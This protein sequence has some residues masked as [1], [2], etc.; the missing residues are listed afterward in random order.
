MGREEMKNC[1]FIPSAFLS[2]FP[3]CSWKRIM[4]IN[5]IQHLHL[6]SHL[7]LVTLLLISLGKQVARELPHFPTTRCTHLHLNPYSSSKD[8]PF[9]LC[10]GPHTLSLSY[11]LWPS[12]IYLTIVHLIPDMLSLLFHRHTKLIFL[13]GLCTLSYLGSKL[14]S[15]RYS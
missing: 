14:S 8:N 7:W 4:L 9:A 12:I 2:W 15:L 3:Y 1:F 11:T 5:N 6:P 10:F 13:L